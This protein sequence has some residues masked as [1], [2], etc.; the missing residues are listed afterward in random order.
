MAE[1]GTSLAGVA[2]SLGILLRFT[3]LNLEIGRQS[4]YATGYRALSNVGSVGV[5]FPTG[6]RLFFFRSPS[7]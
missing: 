6:A 3:L 1:G 4:I 5:Q 2:T 7:W